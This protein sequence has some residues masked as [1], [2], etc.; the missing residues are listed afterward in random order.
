MQWSDGLLKAAFSHAANDADMDARLAK[1]SSW[2]SAC[3]A[4]RIDAAHRL[5]NRHVRT[6]AVASI[7]NSIASSARRG[8]GDQGAGGLRARPPDPVELGAEQAKPLCGVV[9]DHDMRARDIP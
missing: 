9:H 3:R 7:L 8:T 6:T 2:C 1:A 4:M 5:Q